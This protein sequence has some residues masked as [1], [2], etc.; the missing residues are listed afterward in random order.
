MKR[1]VV[2]GAGISGLLA[3]KVLSK[4]FEKVTILDRDT[5]PS[6]P[7]N[8]QFVPQMTQ[9]HI[10]LSK[11]QEI[12]EGLFPGF[13]NELDKEGSPIVSIGRNMGWLNSRGWLS[14]FT[15]TVDIHSCS[16]AFLEWKVRKKLDGGNVEIVGNSGVTGLVYE[17]GSVGGVYLGSKKLEADLVVDAG[18]RNSMMPEWLKALGLPRVKETIVNPYV[19]YATRMYKRIESIDGR[20]NSLYIQPAPPDKLTGGVILPI[21]N[22]MSIVGLVGMGREYPPTDEKGWLGFAR[23]IRDPIFYNTI[24]NA[25]PVA[26]IFSYRN[27]INRVRHYESYKMPDNI[28]A[29]GD[30]VSSF[31]PVYG[32]GMT[33]GSLAS[34]SIDEWL[35][36]MCR[37]GKMTGRM[38]SN[39]FQRKLAE[40]N[41][42]LWRM[43]V[44]EDLLC[45]ETEGGRRDVPTR[46]MEFYLNNIFY[47]ATKDKE[48]AKELVKVMNLLKPQSTLLHLNAILRIFRDDL[49]L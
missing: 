34:V 29:I 24:K 38:D 17:E 42:P 23:G 30:S 32:Q 39:A 12:I 18:G 9:A 3:G 20:W 19:G 41:K 1:A 28:I 37:E 47:A 44:I 21:E 8:R 4:Y 22:N 49:V 43:A 36:R 6:H 16:R 48:I 40:I 11:G 45:R 10:F 14:E 13:K 15:P 33:A 5:L 2:I 31:N 7:A 26:Q 25:V 46:M 35:G 27:I